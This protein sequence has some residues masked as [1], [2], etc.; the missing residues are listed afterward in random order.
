MQSSTQ[1]N[2]TG[3]RNFIIF[4][5][6]FLIQRRRYYTLSDTY[7]QCSYPHHAG[8]NFDSVRHVYIE[9]RSAVDNCSIYFANATELTICDNIIVPHCSIATAFGR[10]LPLSQITK[11]NI[12]GGHV[13][14]VDIITVLRF[15]PKCDRLTLNSLLTDGLD[16][17]LIEFSESFQFVSERNNIT[18]L[19]IKSAGSLKKVELLVNLCPRLQQ[20]TIE[21]LEDNFRSVIKYLLSNNGNMRNLFSLSIRSTGDIW[22]EKLQNTIE[23]EG[24]WDVSVKAIGYFQCYLWW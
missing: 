6:K 15:T 21:V 4:S 2:H 24:R 5:T 1:F 10:I 12:D 19:I 7:K 22:I 9:E 18:K 17:G 11:L 8:S 3:K 13:H 14:F 23:E 20:L 16:L